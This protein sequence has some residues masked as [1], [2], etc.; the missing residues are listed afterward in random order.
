M[1]KS[2]I[3]STRML[4]EMGEALEM[5]V[6]TGLSY[7]FMDDESFSKSRFV[8]QRGKDRKGKIKLGKE[9]GDATPFLLTINKWKNFTTMN[10]FYI[11]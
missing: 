9:W 5:T 4:G 10:D 3:A 6:G 8:Y 1:F 2:P 7:V 11:K